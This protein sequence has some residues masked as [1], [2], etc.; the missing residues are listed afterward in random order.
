MFLQL[1]HF[2]RSVTFAWGPR[3]A[4]TCFLLGSQINIA[5]LCADRETVSVYYY[6]FHYYFRL[7]HLVKNAAPLHRIGFSGPW[8]LASLASSEGGDLRWWHSICFISLSNLS[9][10]WRF[11]AMSGPGLQHPLAGDGKL[12]Q[13]SSLA[14]TPWWSPSLWTQ[15]TKEGKFLH[16][17][18][19]SRESPA[20]GSGG[21]PWQTIPL[22][23]GRS[24]YALAD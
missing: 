24:R 7:L 1:P 11:D 18:L 2:G 3:A 10:C 16:P 19:A 9:G 14:V 21:H 17:F 5:I 13:G 6:L 8:C 22:D 4:R 20:N 12:L 23:S 15:P